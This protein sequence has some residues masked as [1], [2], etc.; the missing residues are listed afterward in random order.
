LIIVL[1]STLAKPIY[2]TN[3]ERR[4]HLRENER[5]FIE[6]YGS[7]TGP[8]KYLTKEEKHKIH[9]MID[10]KMEELEDSGLTREEIL[11]ND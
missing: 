6:S 2:E 1:F 5:N 3:R 4:G 9:I 10:E 8:M 7:P 11:Y